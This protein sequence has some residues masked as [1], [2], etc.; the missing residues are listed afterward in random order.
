MWTYGKDAFA[1]AYDLLPDYNVDIERAQQLIAAAEAKGTKGTLL[2]GSDTDLRAALFV[3]QAASQLGIT[4][5]CGSW[6]TARKVAMRS[7]DGPQD[8][9]LDL[10]SRRSD[11]PDPLSALVRGFN[12]AN[13]ASDITGYRNPIVS[14]ALAARAER[15]DPRHRG[16][17]HDQG[18]GPDHEGRAGDPVHRARHRRSRSTSG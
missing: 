17:E 15:H 9:D 5:T 4:L 6:P 7:S 11:T 3:E 12:P 13:V 10:V 2:V 8:F 1:R 14:R 18:A 16:R